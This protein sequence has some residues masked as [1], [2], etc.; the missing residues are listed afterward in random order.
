MSRKTASKKHPKASKKAEPKAVA[1]VEWVTAREIQLAFQRE[2]AAPSL[3]EGAIEGST[4]KARRALRDKQHST[5]RPKAGDLKVLKAKKLEAIPWLLHGFSTRS[6]GVTEEYGGGQLNLGYTVEDDRKTVDRNR[7]LFLRKL[8]AVKGKAVWPLVNLSQIHST[9]I[10]VVRRGEKVPLKGDGLITNVPGIVLAVKVADCVPVIV[11]DRKRKAVGV[12]HAGWRGTV[13]RIVQKGVGDMRMHFGSRPENLVAAIG[14]AIGK[15]CYEIGDEV[16]SEFE[17]QFAYWR[18]LF[19]DVWDSWSLH[20]KYP[21]LFLNQRAPGHGQA[22][23]SRHLDLVEANYR[24]L[25]D[26]GLLPENIERP[27][28]C[29]GCRTDMF[30]SYRKERV[31]GRMMAAVGMK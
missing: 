8:G 16:E 17:T 14:P 24:Q 13:A 31:T 29:T 11:A 21:L 3:G 25:L 5:R 2:N 7:A 18:E 28:F 1:P 22:A 15:C 23:L 26:A 9:L 20:I 30:F 12:F 27:E 4:I 19:E 10:H 6:G